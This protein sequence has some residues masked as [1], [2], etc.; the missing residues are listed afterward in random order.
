MRLTRPLLQWK[1]S[2]GHWTIRLW[3]S[4]CTQKMKFIW[5]MFW[6]LCESVGGLTKSIY[7]DLS[8]EIACT[9]MTAF[10]IMQSV[11][12]PLAS[13]L[14]FMQMLQ[15]RWPTH[16][17][18][19]YKNGDV[20]VLVWWRTYSWT[21]LPLINWFVYCLYH[22]LTHTHTRIQSFSMSLAIFQ[23]LNSNDLRMALPLA[24]SIDSTQMD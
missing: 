5:F 17:S 12:L 9:K 24:I 1:R 18:T 3:A 7:A 14:L 8:L 23:P 21:Q 6:L 15:I 19:I 2:N 22:T 20:H 10:I 13:S 11:G 16:P 4:L